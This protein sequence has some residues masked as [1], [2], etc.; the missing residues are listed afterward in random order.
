MTV[1]VRE[2]AHAL[3]QRGVSTDIFTRAT[4][5][6]GRIHELFPGV[7]VVCIE[8]GPRAPIAKHELGRYLDDFVS[9]VRA[10]ALSQRI[11]YD[12]VHSHYWQSG[13]AA[14]ALAGFW[15]APMVHSHHTLGRVKNRHLAPGD[16]PE[17]DS[18]LDGESRVISAADVLIAATD[19]EWEQLACLYGAPHDRLKTIHPGVDHDRFAPGD[20]SS[21]RAE[22]GLDPGQAV[23]LYAGRIQPLK[24]LE[25]ALRATEQLVPAL[26][27]ELVLVIVGGASGERGAA[28]LAR[29]RTLAEVLGLTGNVRFVGAQPHARLPIYY[30]AADVVIVCSHS[31]SFGLAALEAQ[32]SGV[33]VVGTA[34]GGLS[35][36]VRDGESGWLIEDRDPAVFAARLKTLLSDDELQSVFSDAALDHAASFSWASTAGSLLELSECLVREK[37][38]EACTC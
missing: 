12:V 15:D 23:M 32:A 22:L 36:I 14:A 24:G 18:R 35:Y 16:D 11:R 4:T 2:V 20:R 31:E 34:V 8:A 1:Y 17:P 19:E 37:L 6:V 13:I 38:P 33:P 26:D 7:R 25:L 28:E 5:D 29:L 30:R 3:A 27:R 21:A 10:F 9:G